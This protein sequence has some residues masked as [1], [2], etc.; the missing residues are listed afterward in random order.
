MTNNEIAILSAEICHGRTC[1]ECPIDGICLAR[2][3]V[4]N[5]DAKQRIIDAYNKLF[6]PTSFTESVPFTEDDILSLFD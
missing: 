4:D 1:H 6:N 3:F 2:Q 5:E